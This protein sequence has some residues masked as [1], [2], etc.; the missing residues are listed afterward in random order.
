MN[1]LQIKKLSPES[2]LRVPES[3]SF[4]ATFTALDSWTR[5][6]KEIYGY[7]T[8][9]FEAAHDNEATGILALTHVRHSIFGNYLATSPF[10]SFGGFAFSSTEAR[11]GL[12]NEA[13]RLSDELK[14]DYAVIRFIEDNNSPPSSWIQNPIY[15]TY[16]LDLPSNPEDLMQT[17][18]HQHRKHT[19]QSLRKGFK[20]QFGHLDLLDITYEALARS[21]HELGSPYHSKKYLQT[22]ASLLGDNLEFAVIKNAD[23]SLVGSAVL[24]YHGVTAT[25]LHANILSQYRAEYAGECLY[26]NILEHYVQKGIKIC[27][28]G[29]S[30]NG[31]GNETFKFKWKP[32]KV[33]LAYWYYLPK[34]GGIPELNQKSPKFQFA[35]WVW[36]R[37]PAFV[38][39]ALGPHLI[40]GIV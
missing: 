26:W 19:R 36:K 6:V 32:R 9:R 18:G 17:F 15:S 37:L 14:V 3:L 23:D 28:M 13:Q 1:N 21:M 22:M 39:R 16:L 24:A 35:I 29:R 11:D 2:P 38:T 33:P 8:H 7:E 12:L 4:P 34:G 27:D 20:V 30:L 10:G 25:N 5:L 31:S 40:R